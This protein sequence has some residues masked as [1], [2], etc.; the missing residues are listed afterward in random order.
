M[1]SVDNQ[2]PLPV[3]NVEPVEPYVPPQIKAKRERP[4]YRQIN[5]GNRP[6]CDVCVVNVHKRGQM[7]IALA[8]WERRER[9]KGAVNLCYEH[10]RLW[11]EAEA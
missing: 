10:A 2:L 11:R 3:D 1:D 7:V 9:G 5:G 8:H 4:V 6:R